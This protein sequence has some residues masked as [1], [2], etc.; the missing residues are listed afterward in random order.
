MRLYFEKRWTRWLAVIGIA[1][2]MSLLEFVFME[3]KHPLMHVGMALACLVLAFSILS[4]IELKSGWMIPLELL[5]TGFAGVFMLHI[6][7]N[8][9]P[10][11]PG[12]FLYNMLL[13][14]MVLMIILA[15]I[16]NIKVA[17]GIWITIC[18]LFGLVD[19][20][21]YEFRGSQIVLN[22]FLSI[23]TALSVAGNY[24][25]EISTQI[26]ISIIMYIAIM[27]ILVRAPFPRCVWPRKLWGRGLSLALAVGLAV[28]PVSHL[29]RYRP[30]T[31]ANNGAKIPGILYEFALELKAMNV[32]PP[33]G[34]SPEN[35]RAIADEYTAEKDSGERSRPH[36]I[37]VMIEAWSDLSVLGN[38]VTNEEVMPFLSEFMPSTIHGQA[39]S[40]VYGGSTATSEWEFLTGNTMAFMPA[41]S[42]V[43]RQ[44]I[45]DD[46]R[47]IVDI[48]KE[49]GYTCIAMHPYYAGGWDRERIY[50]MMGF[51]EMLFLKNTDWG[52]DIVREYVS[53]EAFVD[54]V[55]QQFEDW[56]MD[57]PLFLF[58][59]TMQNHGGYEIE[60]FDA[61]VKLTNP[62]IAA[63]DVDQYLSLIRLTD[64]AMEK[65][66]A[67]FENCSEEVIILA[68][69]DHQPRLSAEFSGALNGPT[70]LQKHIVPYFIWKNYEDEACEKPMT[71]INYLSMMLLDEAGIDLPPY[72]RF[73]K[74]AQKTVPAI[75]GAG[76]IENGDYKDI[77]K[78]TPEQKE[79]LDKYDILEYA[80]VF[81]FS[82]SD[83][84]FT[85]D[86]SDK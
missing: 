10:L 59:I 42:M 32:T 53:D 54:K 50:P 19:S 16:G 17:S 60:G 58:G 69:G 18:W 38:F 26:M 80:H 24:R 37:A 35:V 2:L 47:S 77:S 5:A 23:D 20:L 56:E 25:I 48:M 55:I 34:Y 67:Y 3:V 29:D 63:K 74:E 66:I 30:Y 81:D 13:S 76:I 78:A 65:M 45:R 73:L 39:V 27:I 36:V 70:Q 31:W 4:R 46:V 75:S 68:F 33:E 72:F 84:F 85:G 44:Y 64:S 6:A 62:D 43:Y 15:I 71:S 61:K 86:K 51:E 1:A 49:N 12:A 14:L 22:D 57:N 82:V 41:G 28:L 7:I 52:D 40:S 9:H 21:V 11:R 79:I 8:G 83:E